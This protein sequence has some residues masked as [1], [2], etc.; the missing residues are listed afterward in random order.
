[1]GLRVWAAREEIAAACVT[2]VALPEGL[3]DIEVRDHVRARYGVQLSGGQGAGRLVRIGHMGLTAR[4]MYPIV[5]LAALGRG[6]AD[7]GVRVDVGAGLEAALALLST[8]GAGAES[9]AALAPAA[10]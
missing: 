8:S 7:L 1:M 9:T 3:T 10:R 4:P 6:L 5:G 2:S